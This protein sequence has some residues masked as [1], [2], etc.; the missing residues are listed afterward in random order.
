[1]T[2]DSYSLCGLFTEGAACGHGIDGYMMATSTLPAPASRHHTSTKQRASGSAEPRLLQTTEASGTVTTVSLAEA[3]SAYE[4]DLIQD[5]LRA[6]RGNRANIIENM[7]GTI[8][9][10]CSNVK[11]WRHAAM[12]LCWTPPPACW[13]RKRA[14]A[15]SR[16]TSSFRPCVRPCWN[17]KP[18]TPT[19]ILK[20]HQRLHSL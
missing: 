3:V 12:A 11:R 7:M 13:R 1:M 17:I 15:A 6:T 9:R 16:P 2:V 5:A 20:P 18:S 19:T 14:S 4:K 10:V 8:R